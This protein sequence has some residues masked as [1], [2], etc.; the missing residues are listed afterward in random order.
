MMLGEAAKRVATACRV[1]RFGMAIL[2]CLVVGVPSAAKTLHVGAIS[3]EVSEEIERTHPFARLLARSLS[4]EGITGGRVVVVTD[5]EAAAEK[6][7]KGEIDLVV[8]SPLVALDVADK[9]GGKVF[10]RRW[11]RGRADYRSVIFVR[12][13][14]GIASLSELRGRKI[15]FQEESST[16]AFILPR[17]AILRAGLALAPLRNNA[18]PAPAD[19]LGYVF[20]MRDE[21]TIAWVVRNLVDA[22]AGS[23]ENIAILTPAVRDQLK[24]IERSPPVPRNIAVHRGDL[25]PALV[26]AMRDALFAM[27]KSEEGRKAMAAYYGTTRFDALAPEA[28]T[29]LEELAAALKGPSAPK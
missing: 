29:A 13:D 2:C 21:N 25:A 10:A 5:V 28:M 26:G 8:D 12:A 27:D 4:G 16:T 9:A 23:D 24:I 20:S 6:M 11:K 17:F 14:S 22:G 15:A 7:R 3:T 19:K 18:E 1:G